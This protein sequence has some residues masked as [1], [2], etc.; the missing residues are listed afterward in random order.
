MA[1]PTFYLV[2]GEWVAP[3]AP[4]AAVSKPRGYL[5]REPSPVAGL[6]AARGTGASRDHT[7]HRTY[8]DDCHQCHVLRAR[9]RTRS[10]ASATEDAARRAMLAR[11]P[12]SPDRVP[13]VR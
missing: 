2:R 6:N 3:G 4:P 5:R 12:Y 10:A 7:S 8:Q 9:E 11:D 13:M 1:A